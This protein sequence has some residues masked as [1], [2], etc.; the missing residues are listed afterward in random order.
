MNSLRVSIA[1]SDHYP[2]YA[3]RVDTCYAI[4]KHREIHPLF[5]LPSGALNMLLL[6]GRRTLLSGGYR[7]HVF[8]P[9]IRFLQEHLTQ[10]AR[11]R[12]YRRKER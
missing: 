10:T 11:G 9:S 3:R 1:A 8:P 2:L 5:I 12:S 6:A 4:M 7:L